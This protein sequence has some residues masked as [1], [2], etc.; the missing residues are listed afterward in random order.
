MHEITSLSLLIGTGQC[1]ARCSHC[2]GMALRKY[3]PKI[4]GIID[5]DLI[6]KTI[7]TCY[8]KRA[9]YLSI[10]SSGEPTL[11][12]LSVTKTLE[13]LYG[14]EKEG[15]KFSPINLYSNGIII[16]N[17]KNFC[18]KY[19]SYW[20]SLGLTTIYVTVH[21]IDEK[22]NARIYGIKKYPPFNLVL[23]RIHNAGLLMRANLV[24]G[25]KTINSFDKFVSTV[26]H[27]KKMGVDYI[28]AW[29]I[30]N[31]KDKVDKKLSLPEE[32]LDNIENWVEENPSLKI[33][34]RLPREKSKTA[35][36]K[37]RKLTLFPD[38]SLRQNWCN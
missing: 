31:M 3:A 30:R 1:N 33:R 5:E 11:S 13:L 16:G 29:P 27:L 18:D 37:G 20:K 36:Q 7:K 19:L 24:L 10:S 26:E 38:G 15:L 12:P 6:C 23:S 4:D 8:R 21:D 32:E 9:R 28:S 25:R 22:E 2:A 35:Y 34:I 14:Y 17:N